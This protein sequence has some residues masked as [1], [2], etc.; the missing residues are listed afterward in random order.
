MADASVTAS[1]SHD[2]AR[3]GVPKPREAEQSAGPH[4][5]TKP[6]PTPQ[7]DPQPAPH[8]TPK[9]TAAPHPTPSTAM[10]SPAVIARKASHLVTPIAPIT[11][12]QEDIDACKP[13]GR[14]DPHGT[15]FVTDGEGERQVGQFPDA[16]PDEA[17][18]LYAKRYLDLKSRVDLL[19]ARLETSSITI[20]EIDESLTSLR[21]D[22]KEPTVVGDLKALRSRLEKVSAQAS[23]KRSSLQNARKE[24][25]EAALKGRTAIVEKVEALAAGL[26]PDTIWRSTIDQLNNLFAQWQE[27]QRTHER[28]KRSD[29]VPLW[30]R[31]STARNTIRKQQRAWESQRKAGFAAAKETKEAIIKEAVS[32]EHSTDWRETAIAF[33]ALMDRWKQAGS[34]GRR[35]DDA[36]WAQFHDAS[37]V[38]FSARRADQAKVDS[39]EAENL[40]K[41]EA[42]LTQAEQLVPVKDLAAAKR[43]RAQLVRIQEQWDAIGYVPRRDVRRIEDRLDKVDHAIKDVE[44]AAWKQ[45]NPETEARMSG[46]ERQLTDR[47]A[48]LD[49]RIAATDDPTRQSELKAEKAT[50][51]QWLKAIH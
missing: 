10:P 47:I 45:S 19:A 14:V 48:E 39:S 49:R 40:Q 8:P 46:F 35:N 13:F 28:L 15:V 50:K 6:Q 22:T 4:P 29:D 43:A 38:F 24:A 34:A 9:P 5:T 51:E 37:D 3:P 31:F 1:A 20:H 12:S 11:Y 36:L 23:A 41:K 27:H 21:R 44:D 7:S 32:L 18:T 2:E 42:L 30:K 16:S 33:S 25:Y 26:G 17:L